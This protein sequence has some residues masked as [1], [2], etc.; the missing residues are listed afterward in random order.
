MLL[1]ATLMEADQDPAARRA[2]VVVGPAASEAAVVNAGQGIAA[3][4]TARR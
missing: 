3:N 4:L 1:D 2:G